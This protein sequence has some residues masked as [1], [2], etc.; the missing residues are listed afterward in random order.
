MMSLLSWGMRV[1]VLGIR[2]RTDGL[3]R[4]CGIELRNIPVLMVPALFSSIL[5]VF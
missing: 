2:F 4:L 1:R 3:L 5:C